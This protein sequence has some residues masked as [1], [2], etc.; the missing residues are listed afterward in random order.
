MFQTMTVVLLLGCLLGALFTTFRCT[1]LL[2]LSGRFENIWH[3]PFCEARSTLLCHVGYVWWLLLNMNKQVH[4]NANSFFIS[5]FV[6]V[7]T[8]SAK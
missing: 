2:I 5:G 7:A 6:R 3:T 1:C 8:A 4:V